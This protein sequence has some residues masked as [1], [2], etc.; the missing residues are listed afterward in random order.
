MEL[1]GRQGGQVEESFGQQTVVPLAGVTPE[2]WTP[3]TH[4]QL[5]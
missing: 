4:T 1:G 5:G 3:T 2:K